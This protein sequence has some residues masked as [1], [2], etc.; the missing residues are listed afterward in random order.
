MPLSLRRYTSAPASTAQSDVVRDTTGD[1]LANSRVAMDVLKAVCGCVP[2]PALRNVAGVVYSLLEIA[3]DVRNTSAELRDLVETAGRVVRS[4]NACCIRIIESGKQ[5][6]PDSEQC[7][8]ELCLTLRQVQATCE[9][10][11]SRRW[12]KKVFHHATDRKSC[13]KLKRQLN[14]ASSTF[15]TQMTIIIEQKV[16]EIKEAINNHMEDKAPSGTPNVRVKTE[17]I[18]VD[19]HAVAKNI[20]NVETTTKYTMGTKLTEFVKELNFGPSV[21]VTTA[22]IRVAKGA[23]ASNIGNVRTTTTY[24]KG[25]PT[26]Y[27]HAGDSYERFSAPRV[28]QTE[29][30]TPSPK[31]KALLQLAASASHQVPQRRVPR[32]RVKVIPTKVFA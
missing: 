5:L 3:E 27:S 21:S 23:V 30:Y 10:I 26:E 31:V 25:R 29:D 4:I 18:D 24:A 12:Y 19:P 32:A 14:E 15:Q 13:D 7:I 6:S 20:A 2:V 16:D 8:D 17:T 9:Y 11:R 28:Q 1:V 22:G